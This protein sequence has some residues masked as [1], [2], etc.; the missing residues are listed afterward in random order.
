LKVADGNERALSCAVYNL[1]KKFKILNK[2]ELNEL[3]LWNN[4]KLYNHAGIQVGRVN[5]KIE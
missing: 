3:L 2:K 5:F 1:C 4:H